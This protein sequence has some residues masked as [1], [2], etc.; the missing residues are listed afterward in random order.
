MIT[1]TDPLKSVQVPKVD[2]NY[3]VA[4]YTKDDSKNYKQKEIG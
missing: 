2:Q 4:S 1:S 3:R